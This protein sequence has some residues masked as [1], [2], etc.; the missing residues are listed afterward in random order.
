MCLPIDLV[1]FLFLMAIKT[2]IGA[3]MRDCVEVDLKRKLPPFIFICSINGI[4]QLN[5]LNAYFA[6]QA[7]NHLYHDC[8]L[9]QPKPR[10]ATNTSVGVVPSSQ[11]AG[12]G[13][14][15]VAFDQGARGG[16][17]SMATRARIGGPLGGSGL[18][19]TNSALN[20]SSRDTV[21]SVACGSRLVIVWGSSGLMGQPKVSSS[22]LPLGHPQAQLTSIPMIMD[23]LIRSRSN[24]MEIEPRW[25]VKSNKQKEVSSPTCIDK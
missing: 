14:T 2:P 15:F 16:G 22:S 1:K 13:G 12:R 3:N 24:S 21:G 18:G 6:C 11:G 20:G 5:L 7:K 17:P 8:P 25:Q 4:K 10:E 19:I 23:N 9:L